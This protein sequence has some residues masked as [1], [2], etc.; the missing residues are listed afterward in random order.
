MLIFPEGRKLDDY[1]FSDNLK[2]VL[3]FKDYCVGACNEAENIQA[4]RGKHRPYVNMGKSKLFVYCDLIPPQF[5]GDALAPL[6]ISTPIEYGDSNHVV[7]Y[8][9]YLPV[10]KQVIDVIHV[11]IRCENGDPPPFELGPFTVTLS[12]R[13]RQE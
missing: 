4:I 1:E 10:N 12:I 5:V 9:S 2:D 6:L 7:M 3:G 13:R 8:P 11:F